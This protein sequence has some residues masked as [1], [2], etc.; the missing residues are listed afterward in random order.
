MFSQ[1]GLLVFGIHI[2]SSFL[3]DIFEILDIVQH[4]SSE[5]DT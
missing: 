1:N 3:Y 2:M 4:A 5:H